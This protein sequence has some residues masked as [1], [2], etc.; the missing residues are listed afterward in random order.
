MIDTPAVPPEVTV[1]RAAWTQFDEFNREIA[2]GQSEGAGPFYLAPY[3]DIQPQNQQVLG[4]KSTGTHTFDISVRIRV[5]SPLNVENACVTGPGLFN[6]VR[7]GNSSSFACVRPPS[8][9]GDTTSLYLVKVAGD[10]PT[11]LNDTRSTLKGVKFELVRT[12]QPQKIDLNYDEE[13][14]YFSADGL[15][16]GS[17]RLTELA[18]PIAED[19][20]RYSLLVRPLVFDVRT[21]ESGTDIRTV[22]NFDDDS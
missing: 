16:P 22:I 5:N 11:D 13:T 4:S 9:E 3:G 8:I 6:T 21:E 19:G 14:G 20:T 2:N 18:A 10:R 12:D 17:Y 15:E 7:V 1:L